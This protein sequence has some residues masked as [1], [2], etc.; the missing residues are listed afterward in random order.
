VTLRAAIPMLCFAVLVAQAAPREECTS[1]HKAQAIPQPATSMARA[2]ET[3]AACD[4]LRANSQLTFRQGDYSYAIARDGDRSLYTVSNGKSAVKAP[5]AWAFGLGAA[6]QTYVYQLNGKW[7]ESRVS[8]YKSISG[9]DLTMGAQGNAPKDLEEAAGR[10]MSARDTTECFGCHATNVVR[11]GKTD[12]DHV[13][14]GVMC[15]RCHGPSGQHVASVRT[16]DR[17][18]AGMRRLG[19]L[20]T[21]ELSDFCGQ[22]HRTWAQIAANGPHDI[23]NIRFQPYRLTNSKCYDAADPRIRCV[24]CHDPHRQPEHAAA[25]YDAKCNACHAAASANPAGVSTPHAKACPVAAKSCV[26][27][28]MPKQELPGSHNR[29]TDHRIRIAKAG[30]AYP[31]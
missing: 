20:T 17:K 19:Q 3:A 4:I 7:Y 2:L 13:T 28:H 18:G 31:E 5:I 29:F 11:D 8:F 6:G 15:E 9:L 27:C 1:C 23:N 25:F 10:L 22:C 21:E 26:T 24:A 12:V 14:P 30:E 16:G